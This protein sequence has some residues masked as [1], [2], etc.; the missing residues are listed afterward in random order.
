M[1]QS[2]MKNQSTKK[3]LAEKANMR[4]AHPQTPVG[5][6]QVHGFTELKIQLELALDNIYQMTFSVMQ[7]T[8]QRTK[9]AIAK[10]PYMIQLLLDLRLVKMTIWEKLSRWL[11]TTKQLLSRVL[12]HSFPKM[13]LSARFAIPFV[14]I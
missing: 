6:P 9:K 1:R 7:K 12:V 11:K 3:T 2:A 5:T 8:K 14:T 13:T 4:V 10:T